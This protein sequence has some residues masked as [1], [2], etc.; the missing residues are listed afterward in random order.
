MLWIQV[1]NKRVVQGEDRV[2][3]DRMTIV[4][5][6]E[7]LVGDVGVIEYIPREVGCLSELYGSAVEFVLV[8]I[9]PD[10]ERIE[11]SITSF[12]FGLL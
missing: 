9:I 6:V 4:G 1:K 11:S 5:C 8:G 3:M 10:V 12:D 7:R 2:R